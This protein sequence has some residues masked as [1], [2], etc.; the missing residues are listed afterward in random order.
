MMKV[1]YD[2]SNTEFSRIQANPA[3]DLNHWV[4]SDLPEPKNLWPTFRGLTLIYLI[5]PFPEYCTFKGPYLAA[6]FHGHYKTL[7]TYIAVYQSM[8][9]SI[10]Q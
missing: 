10:V 4:S 8:K 3:S 1:M 6:A 2:R 5:Q 7:A 9:K